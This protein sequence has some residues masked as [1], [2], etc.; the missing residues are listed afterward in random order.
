MRPVASQA[1]GL[2]PRL[3]TARQAATYLALGYETVLDLVKSD[4]IRPVRL[5]DLRKLLFDRGDLDRLID[6]SKT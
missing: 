4:T 6:A 2:S 3:L 1:G 5:G